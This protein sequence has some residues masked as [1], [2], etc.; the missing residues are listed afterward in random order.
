MVHA[1]NQPPCTRKASP[2][3]TKHIQF[4]GVL[5]GAQILPLSRTTIILVRLQLLGGVNDHA[6]EQL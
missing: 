1:S 6:R 4:P 3:A 5:H 2:G